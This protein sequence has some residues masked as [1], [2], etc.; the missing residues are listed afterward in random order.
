MNIILRALIAVIFII[1]LVCV[2]KLVSRDRL[3]LKYS[4]LWILLCMVG[5]VC[6]L[7][8]ELVFWVSDLTGFI[9]PSNFIFLIS[10]ALLLAVSLSLS[11]A[12]SRSAIANKNL[13][14]RIALLEKELERRSATRGNSSGR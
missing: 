10:I 9:S 4:L 2:L 1:F 11:V 13:T 8:P 7:F 3:L 12:V 14:Q 6:D 5:L